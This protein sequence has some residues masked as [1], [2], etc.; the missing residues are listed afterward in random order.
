MDK[1][2]KKIDYITFLQ[3]FA[4]FLVIVGHS[5]PE[6]NTVSFINIIRDFIYTFH[7]PL[8]FVLSGFLFLHSYYRN[9][10]TLVK[11]YTFINKKIIRLI[12]PYFIMGT[13][14][15]L[16]KAF[17]FNRFAYRP[18]E[19]TI[20][21]YLKSMIYPWDNPN[22]SLWFLPTLFI[23]FILDYYLFKKVKNYK[24]WPLILITFSFIISVLSLFTDIKILNISGVLYY[25]FYFNLGLIIYQFKEKIFASI[26][27]IKTVCILLALYIALFLMSDIY[28]FGKYIIAILGILL[29]FI[30]A[31]VCSKN[32]IKF[33]FG[34]MDGK[35]YPIYLLHW[36]FMP[37]FRILY[38]MNL[39]NIETTFF[40]MILS[41]LFGPLI[42]IYIIERFL[43]KF[44]IFIGL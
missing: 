8:F 18:V 17:L 24:F 34:I 31:L 21:F 1:D 32:N 26:I 13:I 42:S 9:K 33:L 39:I 29:S 11:F 20:G 15:Y 12:L 19:N 7:M 30:L 4:T 2:L 10:E 28:E 23:V 41:Q 3:S 43:P 36:F 44:K 40:F 27:N 6:N 16:L 25:L 14:A 22:I 38:Q 37:G 5:A 35:Y